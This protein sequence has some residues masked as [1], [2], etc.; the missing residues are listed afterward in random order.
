MDP[1]IQNIA[2]ALLN[3][4][5]DRICRLLEEHSSEVILLIMMIYFDHESCDFLLICKCI[6]NTLRWTT[7]SNYS[8]NYCQLN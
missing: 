5:V 4:E 7:M 6:W 1:E 2:D 3:E 8:T